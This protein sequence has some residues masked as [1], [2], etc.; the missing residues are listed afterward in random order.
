MAKLYVKRIRDGKMAIEEVP[1]R[2][3]KEVENLLNE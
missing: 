3:R 2:W 1:E